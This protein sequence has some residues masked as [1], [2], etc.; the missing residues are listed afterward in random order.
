MQF[1]IESKVKYYECDVNNK[2]KLSAAMKHMEQCSSEH[3]EELGFSAAHL[4]ENHFVFLL[5]KM[6]IKVHRMPRCTEQIVIGTTAIKPKGVRFAREVAVETPQGERL[7]SAYSLW[8]LVDPESRKVYRPSA[9]PYDLNFGQESMADIIEDVPFPKQEVEGHTSL[10][11]VRYSHLDCNG[12]VNNTMYADF[13]C[14]MLPYDEL[15]NKEIE[16]LIIS[17]Q[18]EAKWGDVIE[19]SSASIDDGQY[20]MRGRHSGKTCFEALVELKTK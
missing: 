6:S 15:C 7:I 3:L 2:M 12:H 19:I 11:S 17:F 8:I 1:K 9:F 5:S 16:K 20:H 14:D 18:N 13:I 10:T 4:M